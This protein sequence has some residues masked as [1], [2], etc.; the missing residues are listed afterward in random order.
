MGYSLFDVYILAKK[1][2]EYQKRWQIIEICNTTTSFIWRGV[3]YRHSS[4][5]SNYVHAF[6][7]WHAVVNIR[8]C[9]A[10]TRN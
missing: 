9:T 5:P 3:G 10:T 7:L 1:L 8:Q 6:D 4:C 2:Y